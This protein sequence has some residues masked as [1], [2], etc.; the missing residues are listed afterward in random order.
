[1]ILDS[2]SLFS[3]QQAVTT[4][5]N[6]TNVI[7]LVAKRDLGRGDPIDFGVII[8]QTF[9]AGGS[10]TLTAAI[11]TADTADLATNPTVLAQTDAIPVAQLTAGTQLLR[12]SVPIS[13]NNPQRYLG[14]VYTVAT[15]PMTAG[16][17]TSGLWLDQQA[18]NA[19]PRGDNVSGF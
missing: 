1:M 18:F 16:K 7:D 2:Q 8:N 3:N 14:V 15:G 10:A 11:V 5:A 6:S 13:R 9:T 17:V 4:T 12:T 19:Y